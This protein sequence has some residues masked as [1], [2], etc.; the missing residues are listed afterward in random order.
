MPRN[1]IK[2]KPVSDFL[3]VIS[4]Y[5]ERFL[6][7]QISNIVVF[8]FIALSQ[9]SFLFILSIFNLKYIYFLGSSFVSNAFNIM[10]VKK[11]K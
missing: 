11:V 4:F 3:Q 8:Y 9:H 7:N 2:N 1:V 10:D 6:L 5:I